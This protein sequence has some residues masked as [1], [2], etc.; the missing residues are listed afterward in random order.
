ME[1]LLGVLHI[2]P[3]SSLVG[4]DWDHRR[5]TLVHLKFS[6]LCACVVHVLMY[7]STVD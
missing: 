3:D 7:S 2:K 5:S 4:A 1:F 6:C